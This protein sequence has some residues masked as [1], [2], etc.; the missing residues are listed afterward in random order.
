[1]D[2]PAPT[3]VLATDFQTIIQM[4]HSL[5]QAAASHQVTHEL[6]HGYQKHLDQYA[7]I[8]QQ[9]PAAGAQRA[10][11]YELQAL[12]LQL[13][14]QHQKAVECL[15]HARQLMAPGD[16]FASGMAATLL[17]SQ[18]A[19]PVAA[20]QKKSIKKWIVLLVAP[21]AAL[22][23]IA[24]VQFIVQ[25]TLNRNT[26]ASFG[27]SPGIG[28]EV[29]NVVSLVVGIAAVL[30]FLAIPVW[31]VM[32]VQTISH[33]RAVESGGSLP[34][35]NKAT[36]VVLAVFFGFWTWLYTYKKD[37]WKFWLNLVLTVVTFTAWGFVAWI[38]AIIDTAVKPDEFYNQL[39]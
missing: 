16:Q 13:G 34:A 1:M 36:A 30:S 25:W 18:S 28:V 12:L 14:G 27:E 33:N 3:Y 29:V 11:L 9:Q 26:S 8:Y 31:I 39:P 19:P 22:V 37:A 38:W 35:K 17:H 2:I 6:L 32:L 10:K 24:L 5:E 20:P 4:I 7:A 15:T 21:F 23:L